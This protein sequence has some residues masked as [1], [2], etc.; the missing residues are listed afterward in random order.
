MRKVSIIYRNIVIYR[1]LMNILYFFR[2][3]ERFQT[4]INEIKKENPQS[5]LDVCFGDVYVAQYCKKN[6]IEWTGLDIN[7]YF[8][9]NAVEN[10]F[11]AL[12]E[13]I[14]Q[15]EKLPQADCVVMIGSLYHFHSQISDVLKKL[16]AASVKNVIISEPIKNLSSS[17]G[18]IGF[19]ATKSADAG[20]GD[21]N[22][23][24]NE[25]SLTEML[26]EQSRVLNFSFE[27]CG[28][29]KKDIIIKLKKNGIS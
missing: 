15:A 4:V 2:Y 18:I 7:D 28:Y 17:G 1:F 14:L 22:F 10:G 20:N 8:V 21:E 11:N 12:K 5:V 16:L 6:K 19:I 3:K 13:D 25:K 24:Y 26:Q 29:F 27:I 23:R 9:K